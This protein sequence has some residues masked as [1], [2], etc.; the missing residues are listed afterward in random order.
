MG[1]TK[2]SWQR[3]HGYHTHCGHP[4]QPSDCLVSGTLDSLFS[5]TLSRPIALLAPTM[6]VLR[7]L[8]TRITPNQPDAG[9][10]P[11]LV[12][13]ISQDHAK[14]R[15]RADKIFKSRTAPLLALHDTMIPIHAD[16]G[17][18]Q[19]RRVAAHWNGA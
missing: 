13:S 15:C 2:P 11:T 12:I 3:H 16:N 19:V 14:Q 10:L 8:S 7:L 6:W 1:P 4:K 17:D 18:G 9:R 5:G